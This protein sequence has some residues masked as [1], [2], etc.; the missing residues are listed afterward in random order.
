MGFS[1]KLFFFCFLE[2]VHK[3]QHHGQ[4]SVMHCRYKSGGQSSFCSLQLQ[5]NEL[6]LKFVYR[7]NLL[8]PLIVAAL[9]MKTRFDIQGEESSKLMVSVV[10]G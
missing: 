6:T 9:L 3:E 2:N 8:R 7:H 5:H 4:C 10:A 1:E